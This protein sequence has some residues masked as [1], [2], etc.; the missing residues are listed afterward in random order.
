MRERRDESFVP[1]EVRD[2]QQQ[3]SPHAMGT[4]CS[5]LSLKNKAWLSSPSV[6]PFQWITDQKRL[7]LLVVNNTYSC[8]DPKITICPKG[9]SLQE[10]CLRDTAQLLYR[11]ITPLV[12]GDKSAFSSLCM[13][14][15]FQGYSISSSRHKGIHSSDT[16]R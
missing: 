12:S 3:S 1:T 7:Y 8:N 10:C 5:Q 13:T 2:F 15:D 4:P 16:S 9:H 14:K 6:I 11:S